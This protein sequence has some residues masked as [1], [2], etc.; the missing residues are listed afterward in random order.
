M[1]T[2]L[3]NKFEFGLFLRLERQMMTYKTNLDR[4]RNTESNSTQNFL[5]VWNVSIYTLILGL[6]IRFIYI[7][8]NYDMGWEPDSYSHVLFATGTFSNLPASL[9]LGIGVWQKPLFTYLAGAWLQI[10]PDNASSLPLVQS[11]NIIFWFGTA[12]V[13]LKMIRSLDFELPT[14]I[15][16]SI[17]VSFAYVFFRASVTA[18]TE[19]MGAFLFAWALYEWV[20]KKTYRSLFL[21]GLIPLVRTDAIFCVIIFPISMVLNTIK[22][23][24]L[25]KPSLYNI[26]IGLFLFGL[27]LFAWNFIGYIH[28]GSPFFILS[29]GYPAA[30]GLYG[31]GA[32]YHYFLKLIEAD[33][34]LFV[35]Y[36]IGAAV[37]FWKWK[38]Q[39]AIFRQI[40]VSTLFYFTAMTLLWSFGRFGSA[41]LLR[42][43]VFAYVGY[44]IIA[45]YAFNTIYKYIAMR[46]AESTV[47]Y[48]TLSLVLVFSLIDLHWL[49]EKPVWHAGLLTSVPS[50]E[51]CM[52]PT[53]LTD[54]KNKDIF[55]DYPSAV[56]YLDMAYGSS[57]LKSLKEIHSQD[58]HGY[59]IFVKGWSEYF[60]GVTEKDFAGFQRIGSIKCPYGELAIIFKK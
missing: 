12:L 46:F 29:H 24:S 47:S 43:F 48:L 14:I 11:M 31:Y 3:C 39:K 41:G 53:I 30:A 34:V 36:W 54:R 42:Y 35:L 33:F 10:F 57:N 13:L 22:H 55:T 21:F 60:S 4:G 49:V 56:Y 8:I 28:T 50:N 58:A 16:G 15:A 26:F 7:T 37:I 5:T 20:R 51:L 2:F 44:I 25:I 59:F 52:L 38:S 18:N 32:V 19:P 17:I 27:P 6:I 40:L 9:W 23:K 1:C 45:L